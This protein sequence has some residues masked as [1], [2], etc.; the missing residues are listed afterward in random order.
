MPFH[1]EDMEENGSKV[2]KMIDLVST[3]LRVYARL[4]NKPKQK[5]GLFAK[6]SLSVIGRCEVAKNPHLFINLANQLIYTLMEP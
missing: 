3:S 5:Y 4:D 1:E 2:P 6:F